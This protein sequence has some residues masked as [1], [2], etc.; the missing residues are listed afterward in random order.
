MGAPSSP[1]PSVPFRNSLP[2]QV[3]VSGS[4]EL[5][6]SSALTFEGAP[7]DPV[8]ELIVAKEQEVEEVEVDLVVDSLCLA[9]EEQVTVGESDPNGQ[10]PSQVQ[11]TPASTSSTTNCSSINIS[12]SGETTLPLPTPPSPTEPGKNPSISSTSPSFTELY[13]HRYTLRTSPRRVL[14]DGIAS[15]SKP[16]SPLTDTGPLKEEGEVEMDCQIAEE[17]VCTDSVGPSSEELVSVNPGDL[18]DEK[19][20]GFLEG[21]ETESTKE[22]T[23][24]Q[25]AEEEEEEEEPDVYY[26][27]SDHLALKHNKEY[28][29]APWGFCFICC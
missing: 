15:P 19:D 28:V 25:A 6:A 16:S 3:E 21:R 24:S 7:E 29:G 9:H 20:G 4:E 18:A 10:L 2:G 27:E 22:L 8:P 17:S 23:R 12:H 5:P 26:F 13:E 11:N 14:S 1:D